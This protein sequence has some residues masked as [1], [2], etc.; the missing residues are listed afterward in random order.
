[1]IKVH[2]WGLL[3]NKTVIDCLGF[4]LSTILVKEYFEIEDTFEL[5]ILLPNGNGPSTVMV[6]VDQTILDWPHGAMTRLKIV[7]ASEKYTKLVSWWL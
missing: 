4:S 6:E 2:C 7:E 1:M 5:Q 3:K